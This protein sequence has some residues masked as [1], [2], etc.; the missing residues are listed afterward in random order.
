MPSHVSVK[1]IKSSFSLQIISLM[2]DDLLAMDLMLNR[3]RLSLLCLYKEGL[4]GG[5]MGGH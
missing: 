1:K 5:A 3:A 4:M 2:E